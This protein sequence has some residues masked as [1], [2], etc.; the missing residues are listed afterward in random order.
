[1]NSE[2][3]LS[4][5]S[6]LVVIPAT[7][8]QQLVQRVLVRDTVEVNLDLL[9][10]SEP[11][12]EEVIDAVDVSL[13]VELGVHVASTD[14]LW[15]VDDDDLGLFG[16]QQN[17]ELVI[18]AMDES[19][20]QEPDH[21]VDTLVEYTQALFFGFQLDDLVEV[22]AIND[23]HD[24]HVTVAVDRPG[25]VQTVLVQVQHELVLFLGRQ[26]GQVQPVELRPVLKIVSILLHSSERHSS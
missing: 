14:H 24:N 1:M 2:V 3:L 12:V 20:F 10:N 16:E 23:L 11:L 7:T 8:L 19:V 15:E 21:V 9:V 22:E 6:D 17:V 5:L 4:V 18:V 26:T 25:H 13:K